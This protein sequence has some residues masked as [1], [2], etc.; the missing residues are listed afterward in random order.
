MSADQKVM[1]KLKSFSGRQ[2]FELGANAA[3]IAG[4]CS[5]RYVCPLCR[6]SFFEYSPQLLT[7]E[8]VPPEAVGGRILVLTCVE[9]N[10]RAGHK[11]QSHQAERHRQDQFWAGNGDGHINLEIQTKK[12]IVRGTASLSGSPRQFIAQRERTSP[13]AQE[14]TEEELSVATL[15]KLG[16]PYHWHKARV[17]DLRNAYLWVFAEFGYNLV[18][19]DFYNWVRED[20]RSG[21][22]SNAK[23][24]IRTVDP[25]SIDAQKAMGSPVILVVDRP[26]GALIVSNGEYGCL[27]PTPMCPDPYSGLDDDQARISVLTMAIPVPTRMKLKWDH[28]SFWEN[29]GS[30][31]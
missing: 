8:H 5:P 22:S 31:A 15:Y 24:G 13:S 11:I 23:W 10:S 27:L 9:C 21:Q 16:N 2:M 19:H 29:L 6:Q 25:V 20:I 7:K 1:R 12:G 30:N 18:M 26:Q 3:A 17:S 28:A 4:N 14:S